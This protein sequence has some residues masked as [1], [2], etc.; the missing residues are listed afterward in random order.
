MLV[1]DPDNIRIAMLGMVDGNGHPYSWS[2]I[3]NGSYDKERMAQ[4]GYPAIPA[5]L[6]AQP[7]SALG[8]AGA[9][10][11]HVWCDDPKDAEKAAAASHVPAVVENATDVIGKVDA[12]VIATDIGHEHVERARPFIEAGIPIFIDKPLTDRSDHLQ[13]F[14]EWHAQGKPLMSTS[15]MRYA[16]EFQ[17]LRARL[18]AIGELR[19]ITVTMAKSWERYGIH[20]IEAIYP[21]LPAGGYKRVRHSGDRKHNV[22]HVSHA[23][24]A[25]V[26]LGVIDDLYGGFGCVNV[27]GTEGADR[28]AFGDTFYAFKTQLEAFIEYLRTGSSPVDFNETIEQIKI[29]IAGM[30]SRETGGA[31]IELI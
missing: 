12:V 17:E 8:I 19:L 10:V 28:A 13:Q 14:I 11:T 20:A 25:E 31:S 4:C 15:C 7:E 26:V 9:Q 18:G 29:V 27:Y 2:A 16:K 22:V 1:D 23:A 6:D 21:F 5:Y 3:I 24:G 30:D